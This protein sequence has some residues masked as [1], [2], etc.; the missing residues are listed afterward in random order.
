MK[1]GILLK[2]AQSQSFV[3]APRERRNGAR[4]EISGYDEDANTVE[5][6]SEQ[7]WEFRGEQVAPQLYCFIWY[8]GRESAAPIPAEIH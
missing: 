7:P 5:R 8:D 2:I 3:L 1:A 4:Y 6:S